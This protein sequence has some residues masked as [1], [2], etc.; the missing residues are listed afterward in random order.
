[1]AM[2]VIIAVLVLD[3]AAVAVLEMLELDVLLRLTRVG[4]R[5]ILLTLSCG[6]NIRHL[7]VHTYSYIHT[8]I[9]VRKTVIEAAH[10]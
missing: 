1:M 10:R 2:F 8:Y 5:G 9:P 4:G 7:S 3:M 6:N